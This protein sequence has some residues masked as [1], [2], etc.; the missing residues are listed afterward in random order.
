MADALDDDLAIAVKQVNN[1]LDAARTFGLPV[2]PSRI[3]IGPRNYPQRGPFLVRDRDTSDSDLSEG[4]DA[5]E[6]SLSDGGV[7]QGV[8]GCLDAG[9]SDRR[10]GE[11]SAIRDDH[12]HGHRLPHLPQVGEDDDPYGSPQSWCSAVSCGNLHLN[13]MCR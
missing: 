9:K 8:N 5:D 3:D 11:G 1:L 13:G 6:E 4:F 7:R 10:Q 2:D 12:S